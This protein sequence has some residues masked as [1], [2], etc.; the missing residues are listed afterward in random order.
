MHPKL[1]LEI[2]QRMSSL[3]FDRR[4]GEL[5]TTRILPAVFNSGSSE[6]YVE[7]RFNLNPGEEYAFTFFWKAGTMPSNGECV[8]YTDYNYR[9]Y[10]ADAELTTE[11]PYPTGYNIYS[12]RFV[13]DTS[14]P[15]MQIGFYCETTTDDD[16]ASVYIDDVSLTSLGG[17]EAYPSTGAF[18]ENPSFEI[19]ATEDSTYAWFGTSGVTIK[20]GTSNENDPQPLSGNN[21]L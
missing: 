18:I 4:S 6:I 21:F 16:Q 19:R 17:C 13:P 14:N 7:Q 2:I 3:Q 11:S 1:E 10:Y 8:V 5:T 20:A 12:I 15:V 9:D